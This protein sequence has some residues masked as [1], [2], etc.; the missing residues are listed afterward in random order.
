MLFR[1]VDIEV[2]QKA[3][4]DTDALDLTAG[5]LGLALEVRLREEQ[6]IDRMR[7][8]RRGSEP[9]EVWKVTCS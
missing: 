5:A 7:P 2:L 6:H 1:R 4:A 9:F 3:P 8:V